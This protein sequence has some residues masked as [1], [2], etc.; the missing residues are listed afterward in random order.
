MK[1]FVI[2]DD[3]LNYFSKPADIKRWYGDIFAQDIPV[4][5]ATIPFVTT[6]SDVYPGD[7]EESTEEHS[8]SENQDLVEY[9]KE[10]NIIEILQHGCTHLTVNEV[11]EYAKASGLVEDTRRGKE[12]LEAAFGQKIEVFVAP[13][14][15]FSNHAIKATETVGLHLLRGRGS[16][17]LLL[18]PEYISNFVKMIGHKL[19]HLHKH[20][21]YPYVLDFGKHKE[22]YCCRLR[23]DNLDQLKRDLQY[24]VEKG[25]DFVITA[26]IHNLNKESKYNLLE[27]IDR[28]RDYGFSFCKPSEPFNQLYSVKVYCA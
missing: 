23:V 28:A 17:N 5:F 24:V 1:K 7:R 14:D 19:A 10:N 11:F 15:T 8:I 25:G 2:R 13:H 12:E 18:R 20:P 9:V 3:D 4:G 6:A 16:K 27:I 21:P 26:H 22:V